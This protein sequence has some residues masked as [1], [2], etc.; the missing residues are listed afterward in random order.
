MGFTLLRIKQ[1][2]KVSLKYNN[3]ICTT[4]NLHVNN[5]N[6]KHYNTSNSDNVIGNS[7][8]PRVKVQTK[9]SFNTP[10]TFQKETDTDSIISIKYEIADDNNTSEEISCHQNPS[11]VMYHACDGNV[12]NV[13]NKEE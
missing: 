1:G 9:S 6:S 5:I 8:L 3:R 4:V 7:N 10:I 13:L 2:R 12:N 11:E